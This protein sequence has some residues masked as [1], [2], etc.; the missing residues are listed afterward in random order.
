MTTTVS[1]LS[2]TS[3]SF[4][5]SPYHFAMDSNDKSV[6]EVVVD[7]SRHAVGDV[8]G[9]ARTAGVGRRV[10]VA[11]GHLQLGGHPVGN[12]AVRRTTRLNAL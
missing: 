2:I 4:A 6:E 3:P 7:R 12:T 1:A 8:A 5:A 9:V 11:G 10:G